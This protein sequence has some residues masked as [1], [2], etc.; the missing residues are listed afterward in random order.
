MAI[1]ARPQARCGQK[2]HYQAYQAAKMHEMW[3]DTTE[4]YRKI[5]GKR[6]SLD[7]WK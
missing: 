1:F 5:Y 3:G 6:M 4:L 2:K 7:Y